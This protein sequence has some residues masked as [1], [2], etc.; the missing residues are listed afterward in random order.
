WPTSDGRSAAAA[1]PALDGESPA[2]VAR[3]S[4][5][6]RPSA[7]STCEGVTAAAVPPPPNHDVTVS[8]R[9]MRLNRSTTPASPPVD[10]LVNMPRRPFNTDIT[11]ALLSVSRFATSFTSRSNI[12]PS[13]GRA[14]GPRARGEPGRGQTGVRPGSNGGQTWNR[15]GPG[16][17]QERRQQPTPEGRVPF[18]SQ[19]QTPPR[20]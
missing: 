2:L 7:D 17:L 10:G 11:D 19:A 14:G 20:D 13:F 3:R 18:G 6:L 5:V 9:P 12:A 16:M 1:D 15:S 4:M 8:P